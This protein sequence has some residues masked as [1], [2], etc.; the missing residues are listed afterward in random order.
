MWTLVLVEY[1]IDLGFSLEE[2]E[3]FADFEIGLTSFVRS[4]ARN[5]PSRIYPILRVKGASDIFKNI[6][7]WSFLEGAPFGV[8]PRMIWLRW[9]DAD[10]RGVYGRPETMS[11]TPV[12][13]CVGS[14]SGGGVSDRS[15]E[16]GKEPYSSL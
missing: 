13:G 3:A 2:I 8:N 12:K 5:L 6:G 15:P 14:K 10:V 7:P 9:S 11:S 1:V 16:T 4:A